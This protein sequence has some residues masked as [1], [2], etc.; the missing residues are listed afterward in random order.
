MSYISRGHLSL[1]SRRNTSSYARGGAVDSVEKKFGKIVRMLR[2]RR[3]YNQEEF[4]DLIETERAYY[5]G[6]ER[7]VYNLTLKK[8][9]R[10]IKALGIRWSSFFRYMDEE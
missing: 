6:I 1:I 7:G 10:I 4:A 2:Q 5:G 9:E 8:I 3:G